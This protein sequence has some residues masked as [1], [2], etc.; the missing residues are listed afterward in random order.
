MGSGMRRKPS[1]PGLQSSGD[2]KGGEGEGYPNHVSSLMATDRH[3]A[4]G[5][6][7]ELSADAD[8]HKKGDTLLIEGQK[9]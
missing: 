5:I 7:R 3:M 8:T 9:V 2:E 4:S 6:G 1:P